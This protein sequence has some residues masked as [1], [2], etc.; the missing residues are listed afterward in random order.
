M[1]AEIDWVAY[2]ADSAFRLTCLL[3]VAT[4]IGDRLWPARIEMDSRFAWNSL[5]TV[6]VVVLV[7]AVAENRLY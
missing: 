4:H 6:A 1:I 7:T 5:A 2:W 3:A